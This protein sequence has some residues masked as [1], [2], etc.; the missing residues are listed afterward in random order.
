MVGPFFL[1]FL[2]K[3]R[4]CRLGS[5]EKFIMHVKNKIRKG[6]AEPRD[7]VIPFPL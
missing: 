3:K 7:P 5:I 1:G 6:I 4:T 2:F